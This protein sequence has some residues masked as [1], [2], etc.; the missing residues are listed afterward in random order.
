M[1]AR[2]EAEAIAKKGV[3]A[4]LDLTSEFSEAAPL[5]TVAYK[6][7]PILDLTA[8]TTEQLQEAAAFI[9]QESETGIV[10]VHC[11]IGYSRTAAIAAAYLLRA[12]LAG[13]VSE[14]IERIRQARPGI[15]IRPEVMTAVALLFG[16]RARVS[17]RLGGALLQ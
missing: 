15:V 7:I 11:K 16:D 12:G 14:A 3:T 5:R 6:N 1:L 10:Y 17:P 8:P 9:Q 2:R 4:V 13:S